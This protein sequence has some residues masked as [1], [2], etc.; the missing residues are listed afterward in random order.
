MIGKHQ[1]SSYVTYDE[2]RLKTSVFNS[3]RKTIVTF[4]NIIL[5]GHEYVTNNG[6]YFHPQKEPEW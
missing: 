5:K 4:L 3:T 2:N 1:P 6:F